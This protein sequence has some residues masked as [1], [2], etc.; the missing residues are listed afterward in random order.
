MNSWLNWEELPI[1][2]KSAAVKPYYDH[3]SKKRVALIAKRIFDILVSFL[4]LLILSPILLI[5][6]IMIKVDSQ[7]PIFYRQ[8]RVA[9]YGKEFRIFKFRT[10]VANADQIGTAVTLSND[11]R[12]TR[13]GSLMRKARLDE[14][15][16]LINIIK[17]EMS[18]VGTRPE[19]AKYVEK[20][21][22]EMKATLLLP[23]GLTSL[24]SIEFKDE[25]AM[26]GDSDDVDQIYIENVLPL[27]MRFNLE[28]LK[29]FG[30]VS[31]FW[32]MIRTFIA[33]IK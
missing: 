12:I 9:R 17:G 21:T 20:Y 22:D 32:L 23:P 26:L 29:S 1:E 31:D 25:A 11:T 14:F 15:P 30:L 27:K 18:F 16:Q 8:K 13:M 7:G 2:L 19:V 5:L 28:Y 4:L 10:M 3:L 33:V 6:G 24:A